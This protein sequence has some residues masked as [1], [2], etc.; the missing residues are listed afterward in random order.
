MG[1]LNRKDARIFRGYFNEMVKLIG[2]SVGY[3]W[4]VKREYTIH[5][6]DN[7]TLS[8]PIRIDILFDENP[9]VDT[10]NRL[11]WVSELNNEKPIV[12]N[13]PYNTPN[14]TINAR[15]TI[16]SVDGVARPRVFKITQIVSDLEFPDAYTCAIVPVFD[17][18]IQKNQY[19]LVNH[20]KINQDESNRTSKDQPY[21]Y[22][23]DQ[24]NIDNTPKENIDYEKKYN[25]INDKKSP[26]SG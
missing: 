17:Q 12:I 8:A 4:V 24:H 3:Q 16:E 18:H 13:M 5:S 7:S 6:E 19:T 14:L 25:F 1:L 15:I 9:Q 23:T 20:E 10:L 21:K 2:Q 11:G 26:Y 22:I